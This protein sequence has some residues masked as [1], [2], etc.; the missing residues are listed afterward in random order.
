MNL[1]C[2]VSCGICNPNALDL[3]LAQTSHNDASIQEQIDNRMA[4]AHIYL[5]TVAAD[6]VLRSVLPGC[7]NQ[8]PSC[9]IWA[10]QGEV[11]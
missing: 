7:K 2:R 11:S 3:G 1:K 6:N 5:E 4:Q 8:H 9:V 10:M